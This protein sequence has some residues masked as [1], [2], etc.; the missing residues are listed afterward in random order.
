MPTTE[1]NPLDNLLKRMLSMP[2]QPKEAKQNTS[3]KPQSVKSKTP[4]Q[5]HI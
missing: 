5:N 3:P 4:K 1:P 2:P